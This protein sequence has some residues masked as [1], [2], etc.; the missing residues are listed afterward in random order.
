MNVW[1]VT[2]PYPVTLSSE[3]CTQCLRALHQLEHHDATQLVAVCIQYHYDKLDKA[4]A[5]TYVCVKVATLVD[6]TSW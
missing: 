3:F 6:P 1:Y 4:I 2:P 5:P